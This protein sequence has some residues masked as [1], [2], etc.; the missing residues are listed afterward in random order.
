MKDSNFLKENNARHMW[1]PMAHPADSLANPPEIITGAKAC[2]ITDVD[3]TQ[4]ST[5]SA[6]SG[7]SIWAIPASR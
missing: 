7:T 1:H 4:V 2:E 5:P 3:G 6:G